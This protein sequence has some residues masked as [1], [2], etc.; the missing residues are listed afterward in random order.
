MEYFRNDFSNILVGDTNLP[1]LR[2]N[3]YH[4][5]GVEFTDMRKY[6]STPMKLLWADG[7]EKDARIS[8]IPRSVFTVSLSLPKLHDCLAFSGC[9][10]NMAGCLVKN[11]KAI[12]GVEWWSRISNN[13][14]AKGNR[15]TN[16][17]LMRILNQAKP[18]ISVLD[19]Y[20][21]G[22]RHVGVSMA[23]DDCVSVDSMAAKAMGMQ[24]VPHLSIAQT[25]GLG[26]SK[27]E[28]IQIALDG[29]SSW[30][31]VRFP[32]RPQRSYNNQI[33]SHY[34]MPIDFTHPFVMLTRL[35][36][37]RDMHIEDR[38]ERDVL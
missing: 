12:H 18:D 13:R 31:D 35:H 11:K 9:T 25:V 30:D 16:L 6:D 34:K 2:D 38:L 27:P 15:V 26:I 7:T 8:L 17:N 37:F 36:R 32:V 14:A 29:V 19:F 24:Y 20:S 1:F 10:E 21:Y 22:S 28:M 5:D 4:M 3:I 33:A 23:S